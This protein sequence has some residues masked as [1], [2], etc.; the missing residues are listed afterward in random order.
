MAN[1]DISSK[2]GHEKQ[3]ITIAEGKTYEVDCSAETML[4][5]Q[6]IFK[7]DESLEGLFSAIK[8]LIGVKA[9]KDIREMKLTVNELKTVII[10]IMAQVN[11]VSYEEMEK[12]F[13]NK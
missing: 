3:E 11:E 5:A 2:L 9:E 6:D 1:L 8:L 10:A 4:K 12:R 13:Q 7:K